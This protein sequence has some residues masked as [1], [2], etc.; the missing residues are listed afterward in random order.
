MCALLQG[1]PEVDQDVRTNDHVKLVERSVRDEVVPCPRDVALQ[2][3]VEAR[4]AARNRVV[5]GQLTSPTR[6]RVMALESPNAVERICAD[7]SHGEGIRVEVGGVDAGAPKDA[8]FLQHDGQGID[9]LARGTADHPD[10]Y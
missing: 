2:A 3:T 7:S 9:L 10:P 1:G 5:V 8:L 6:P 4:A